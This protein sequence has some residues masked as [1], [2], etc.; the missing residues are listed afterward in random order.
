MNNAHT[1][2]YSQSKNRSIFNI[3]DSLAVTVEVTEDPYELPLD[4]FFGMAARKNKKRGFLFVSKIL[5]KHIPVAPVTSLLS[6]AL[7]A[8]RYLETVHDHPIEGRKA[9]VE[10]LLSGSRQEEIYQ[11]LM[12]DPFPLAE[13]TLFIGFAETATAL[14][15]SVF[16]LFNNAH[17]LHTTREQIV[18]LQ[19]SIEFEEEHSHATEQACYG[20]KEL[21]QKDGPIVLVD[22]EITTG[23]TALNIIESIHAAYP[24]REYV[25]LSLLD[26]RSEANKEAYAKLEAKLGIRIRTATLL[27]GMIKVDGNPVDTEGYYEYT[28]SDAA[29]ETEIHSINLSEYENFKQIDD[30]EY[31][32]ISS[33]GH[34]NKVP[35]SGMTGRFNGISS[36]DRPSIDDY[37][38]HVGVG[39]KQTRSGG[40]TLCLGTGEFMY[41]PMKIASYMGKDVFYQSTTRS[42]I[43]RI[44]KEG[45]AVTSGFDFVNPDDS[46][47]TNYFYNIPYKSYQDIYLFLERKVTEVRLE[48]LLE[49]IKQV[50]AERLFVVTVNSQQKG[51]S[52]AD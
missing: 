52:H 21:L 41:L 28:N 17:Y 36:T 12:D 31:V 50:G 46:A 37:A 32:S 51:E 23:K 10:A 30:V 8:M 27:A 22:D 6:G 39:L 43:H 19:S 34:V 9:A 40:K 29:V 15:H 16:D 4:H 38:F 11:S 20:N 7:L 1:L 24:R 44:D 3:L 26:W 49:K 45:Y 35:Y 33:E 2:I 48:S 25:V 13:E 18:G 14:G 5:G 47:I 42:P